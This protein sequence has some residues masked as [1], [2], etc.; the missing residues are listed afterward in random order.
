MIP[1]RKSEDGDSLFSRMQDLLKSYES[2]KKL[3]LLSE[4]YNK[5]HKLSISVINELRNALDHIMR[6]V[7]IV[8]N[9]ND[10]FSKA[11]GHIYR[12]AFDACEIIVL[13]RLSYIHSFKEKHGI[14]I[15]NKLCPEYF[16]KYLPLITEIKSDL[17]NVR[18]IELTSKR[19]TK[20][21]HITSQIIELCDS[22][23]SKLGVDQE[24]I[25][26]TKFKRSINKYFS[27]GLAGLAVLASLFSLLSG[28]EVPDSYLIGASLLLVI[29]V[30]FLL[31]KKWR[32]W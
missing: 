29:I 2:A 18:T 6:G 20:Y 12:S 19:L 9:I 10:E 5:D 11:E 30:S 14:Q 28:G 16:E 27:S 1:D 25:S 4:Y 23:D 8:N 3:I 22:L 31:F 24:V 21:E 17:V 15:I 7:K 13:N 32:N 26:R